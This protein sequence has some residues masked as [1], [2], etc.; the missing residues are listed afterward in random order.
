MEKRKYTFTQ[1]GML[2]GLFI[3]NPIGVFLFVF[4]NNAN[5]FTVTG[6]G[7]ALGLSIGASK[8]RQG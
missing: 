3:A 7:L 5:Y 2:Y 4:I 1:L 6:I 8:D